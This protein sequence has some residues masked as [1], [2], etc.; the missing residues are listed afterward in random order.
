[1]R[2]QQSEVSGWFK[3][4]Q[5]VICS[6]LEKADS[7]GKFI[8]DEWIRPGGG[9]GLTRIIRKGQVIEKGG[10]NFSAVH[11]ESPEFLKNQFSISKA[12]DFFATGI[13]IVIHPVNPFVPIIHMNTRY[14]EMGD[15]AWFG[16]G[17]DL[18]PH[19]IKKEDAHFFHSELKKMCD[20]FHADY[21]PE[22]KKEADDYFFL[23]HRN[24]TR[25]VG[26]IFF[27]KLAEKN[28]IT[29]AYR[30]DF[31]KA[32]GESFLPMYLELINRNKEEKYSESNSKWQR[33]RRGRYV[34]FNL[35]YDKG[36]KFGL[37]TSGRTESILMSLP[38]VVEWEYDFI[39]EQGSQ[40]FETLRLL[41][42]GIDW[43]KN[44]NV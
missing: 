19:Y 27:D 14:F 23:P 24:E 4:L 11:G 20:R 18:T 43:T 32:T 29:M 15:H 41:R 8:S 17:I 28:E 38:P 35:I 3:S 42:K 12:I 6:E 31:V 33:L 34:E 26:G 36:T 44:E 10:V 1:V 40:E 7:T 16:G 37:E 9:G 13:S 25:G 21:Y 30:F 2:I 39:P 5:E 22:F